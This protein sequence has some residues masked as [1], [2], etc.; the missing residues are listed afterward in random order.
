MRGAASALPILLSLAVTAALAD[1]PAFD[2]VAADTLLSDDDLYRLATC[3][4]PPGQ[5][6]RSPP[7]R[8]DKT[9]LTLAFADGDAA[10]PAGL[11]AD[12]AAAAGHALAEI[13]ATGAGIRIVLAE[14]GPAD[15]TIRPTA[16]VEGTELT[17]TPGV[18]GSGIMGVG[19]ATVWFDDKGVISEAVIL[20][21]TSI[22]P[23]D[24]ASVLLEEI[25]QSLGFPYDIEGP[26]YEG[27]SIL[28]QGSNATTRLAGQDVVLLRRHYPPE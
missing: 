24:V 27:V 10:L 23:A 17:E 3:G 16:T 22:S 6:C 8:W 20:V 9:L 2:G 25:V 1:T 5:E 15:I 21:S 19:F 11:A 14:N 26:A 7:L 12:L 4:A 28:S 18:S 13:N